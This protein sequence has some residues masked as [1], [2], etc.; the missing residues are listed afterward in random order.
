MLSPFTP[1]DDGIQGIPG[2]RPDDVS[3]K[4]EQNTERLNVIEREIAKIKKQLDVVMKRIRQDEI[5]AG[6]AER[7]R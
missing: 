6:D 1:P 4:V 2:S 3:S 5:L 7:T